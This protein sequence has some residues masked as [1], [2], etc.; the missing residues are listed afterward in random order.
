MAVGSAGNPA[1]SPIGRQFRG[2]TVLDVE[3]W[4]C[5]GADGGEAQG[6]GSQWRCVV[7]RRASRHTKPGDWE[8]QKSPM[9]GPCR[10]P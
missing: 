6:V 7:Q 1:H 10:V 3:I 2:D 5:Q 9:K 8:A 4:S